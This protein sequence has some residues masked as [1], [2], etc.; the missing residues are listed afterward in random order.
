MS[1]WMAKLRTFNPFHSIKQ[2][3][4]IVTFTKIDDQNKNTVHTELKKN[5]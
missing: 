3:R 2:Y 5:G 4:Y 1:G